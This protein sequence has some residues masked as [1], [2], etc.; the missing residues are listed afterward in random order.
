MTLLA[1]T[2]KHDHSKLVLSNLKSKAKLIRK[3]LLATLISLIKKSNIEAE[4][5]TSTDRAQ[6]LEEVK[7]SFELE[8]ENIILNS[9]N[10]ILSAMSKLEASKLRPVMLYSNDVFFAKA[11]FIDQKLENGEIM[12]SSLKFD[13]EDDKNFSMIKK[14]LQRYYPEILRVMKNTK[15]EI[16]KIMEFKRNFSYN[17]KEFPVERGIKDDAPKD[18]DNTF[19]VFYQL[20]MVE[21]EIEKMFIYFVKL[22]P[23]EISSISNTNLL[24]FKKF[25]SNSGYKVYLGLKEKSEDNIPDTSYKHLSD[26]NEKRLAKQFKKWNGLFVLNFVD[27]VIEIT[28]SLCRT[29][30]IYDNYLPKLINSLSR[31]YPFMDI[32]MTLFHSKHALYQNV[33][34]IL[35]CLGF[36]FHSFEAKEKRMYL[37]LIM[38][39][40]SQFNQQTFKKSTA[41]IF[42]NQEFNLDANLEEQ[43]VNKDKSSNSFSGENN[44]SLVDSQI[45]NKVL[46]KMPDSDLNIGNSVL[47]GGK[48]FLL[49]TIAE[50]KNVALEYTGES[51]G[52]TRLLK[53]DVSLLVFLVLNNIYPKYKMSESNIDI[54]KYFN[55]H[56]KKANLKTENGEEIFLFQSRDYFSSN[57][58]LL[59]QYNSF[60]LED[61]LSILGL[62]L[63]LSTFSLKFGYSV[64]V[65]KQ[66][67]VRVNPGDGNLVARGMNLPFRVYFFSTNRP[68]IYTY[69]L[70][71][72]EIS[73]NQINDDLSDYIHQVFS[74]IDFNNIQN[75]QSNILIPHFEEKIKDQMD[76]NFFKQLFEDEQEEDEE[77][78]IEVDKIIKQI[79]DESYL[80][81][82]SL[83]SDSSDHTLSESVSAK[84]ERQNA[85]I[86]KTSFG[87]Y[88]S[89]GM[90]IELLYSI[91]GNY[92]PSGMREPE[93]L[94]S[95]NYIGDRFITGVLHKNLEKTFMHPTFSLL[96][97]L[98]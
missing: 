65:D 7:I 3:S 15:M 19:Q 2:S 24:T 40:V 48:Y 9:I 25:L 45:S 41:G 55:Q 13:A 61:S 16:K 54:F 96:I 67:Y 38:P 89:R 58:R 66:L 37:K 31:L 56:L 44:S 27:Q 30:N 42:K 82:L 78:K 60:H 53:C 80:E 14:T 77:K 75:L 4:Y 21:S 64:K 49:V 87:E 94:S 98:K 6:D 70:V 34:S 43:E 32:G 73:S 59:P 51:I 57:D 84:S 63:T 92:F 26:W 83:S 8:G 93:A 79:K 69:F 88:L 18:M 74:D 28:C 23:E 35:L 10:L 11:H 72:P 90:T 29:V 52:S 46:I 5:K 47:Q 62:G 33:I 50:Q 76:S 36:N 68:N 1:I 91:E 12:S 97:N 95:S 20:N 86:Y 85:G 81:K 71:S 22:I 39:A 17:L